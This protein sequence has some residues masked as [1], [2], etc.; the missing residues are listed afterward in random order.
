MLGSL[1]V[2]AHEERACSDH[3]QDKKEERH[4]PTATRVR[5]NLRDLLHF[6]KHFLFQNAL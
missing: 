3:D 4:L 5:G 1:F 2:H 6:P